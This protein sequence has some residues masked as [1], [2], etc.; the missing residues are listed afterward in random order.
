M[1][2]LEGYL[3]DEEA[4]NGAIYRPELNSYAMKNSEGEFS[5][6]DQ[7]NSD[8]NQE[9][10][11]FVCENSEM[12]PEKSK[13][14]AVLETPSIAAKILSNSQTPGSNSQSSPENVNG[15]VLMIPELVYNFCLSS[16]LS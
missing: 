5:G 8:F 7:K 16:N 1:D 10:S 9:N 15:C 2:N 3:D 14:K 6:F 13:S 11:E 12:R 4:L